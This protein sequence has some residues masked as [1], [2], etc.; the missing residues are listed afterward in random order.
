MRRTLFLSFLLISLLAPQADA[1]WWRKFLPVGKSVAKEAGEQSTE[2]SKS[3]LK[4]FSKS[5]PA[6]SGTVVNGTASTREIANS[7]RLSLRNPKY[8]VDG[9]SRRLTARRVD[10]E[11]SAVAR[12]RELPSDVRVPSWAQNRP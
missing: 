3:W 12:S 9:V 11:L 1:Q 5:R 4:F 2:V 7:G 6:S 8:N 10:L